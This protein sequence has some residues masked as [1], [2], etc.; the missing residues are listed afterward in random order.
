VDVER[1]VNRVWSKL[2]SSVMKTLKAARAML[3]EVCAGFCEKFVPRVL[4][5]QG[6]TQFVV[7]TRPEML[8]FVPFN[9]AKLQNSLGSYF[10]TSLENKFNKICLQFYE[11]SPCKMNFLPHIQEN[12]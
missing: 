4:K 10:H 7:I 2:N 12:L 3:A 8:F 5:C 6:S 1:V 9:Y 11:Y